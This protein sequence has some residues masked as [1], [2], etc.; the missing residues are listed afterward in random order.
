MVRRRDVISVGA[1]LVVG[2]AFWL[3]RMGVNDHDDMLSNELL[4]A[5][6]GLGTL[7]FHNP[8]PDQSPL[9]FVYLHVL[10]AIGETPF[11]VQFANA[12]LLSVALAVTYLLARALSGTRSVAAA[13]VFIGAVS[14]TS[15]W[16]VRNGRMYSLQLLFSVLAALFVVRYLQHRRTSDVVAFAVA[17]ALN[18][19]THFFGFL[20]T[21]L[22]FVVLGVDAWRVTPTSIGEP[23]LT[24]G[25]N[26]RRVATAALLL[27]AI[28][29]PQIVRLVSFATQ[30]V[31]SARA[32]VS[33]PALSP[34]FFD[35]VSWFWFVNAG[36][37]SLSPGEQLIT[38]V[39]VGSILILALAGLVAAGRRLGAAVATWI[40]VPLAL[41]SLAAGRID[42][43][44][45]YF[46]WTLPLLW[47]AVA[48]GALGA[49][50]FARLTGSRADITRGIRAALVVG[51]ITGSLWL[52]WNKLPE[53]YSEWTKLMGVVE[54]L[55]RPSMLAYMPPGSPMG[56]P[57]L[58]AVQHNMPAGLRDVR[59]LSANTHDQ[60]LQE[61]ERQQDFIFFVYAGLENEEMRS[62]VR[63]LEAHNY[64]KATVPTYGAGAQIFTRVALDGW[65]QEQRVDPSPASIVSWARQ[66]LAQRSASVRST[67]PLANA[68][69]ARVEQSGSARVGQLFASQRG[70]FGSWRLGPES[71]DAVE[72]Q[73]VT[74]GKV[75]QRS[76]AAHPAS[77]S[78]L[79]VALPQ[80]AMGKS[81]ALSYGIADT[82]IGFRGGANVDIAVYV[83]GVRR[84]SLSCSNTPGWKQAAVDTAS[85]DG[86]SA[87]TVLL[88]TT[89][90][91]RSR[92][93]AFRLDASSTPA[94]PTATAVDDRSPFILTGGHR[95]S[96][97]VERL[98]VY[99]L[100][101]DRRID[102]VSDGQTYSASDMHETTGSGGEGS[103]HRV[104]A[105]GPLPWDAVG[106]TR[107]VSGGEARKGIWAHP[108]DGTT[109]VIEAS[110]VKP[111]ELLR[112]QFGFSNHGV[113]MAASVGVTAPLT[114]R[115]A[116]DGR[117]VF[118]QVVARSTGWSGLA[119]P[120]GA[121][122]GERSLRIEISSAADKWGHFVF[123]LWSE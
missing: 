2:W 51:V 22:M 85:L 115:I 5:R 57:R 86:Q 102:G 4:F 68:F 107:Q 25:R 50:P 19:Y 120:L 122:G 95:L 31:P 91:D 12:V 82:G 123:D 20:I 64:R 121:G 43:R 27:A 54:R 70:E 90:D 44:D 112:G 72:D 103:V 16:L 77:G 28:A 29:V 62:R 63:Y 30:S 38:V 46:V 53:R 47:V 119:V 7:L 56:I 69:V 99:R 89:A 18:I 65:S 83:N 11:V 80:Q 9:Y 100:E 61:V 17:S 78:V 101:G 84:T 111:G 15:L 58:I 88:L 92:H 109:L 108:R 75:E 42:I 81:L 93:F 71:W 52:L 98:R 105:F 59:D 76:I 48:N 40:V 34:R 60:F 116:V 117:T 37:G 23:A 55:Y 13:A 33:L 45:R 106:S 3:Y 21:G 41:A 6:Q 8:W 94:A 73:P 14:P 74:A 113:E 110:H 49:M 1:P 104:W 96:D 97:R 35:R 26:L 66:Q 39:Y 32:D 118:E 10:R 67:E 79:V 87:D 24:I 36:W 114:F